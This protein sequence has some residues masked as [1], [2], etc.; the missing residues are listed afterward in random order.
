MNFGLADGKYI[1]KK[2]RARTSTGRF[3]EYGYND[4]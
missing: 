4:D 2:V 3:K 1:K